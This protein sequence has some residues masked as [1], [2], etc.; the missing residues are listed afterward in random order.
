[1]LTLRQIITGKEPDMATFELPMSYDALTNI[2]RLKLLCDAD[3]RENYG[4][5]PEAQEC[6]RATNGNCRLVWD[7]TYDPPGKHFLQARL[8]IQNRPGRWPRRNY[9]PGETTLKGPLFAFVSTNVIQF[10]P[11]SNVLTE[12]G[13]FFQIKLAQPVGS[14]SLKLTSATG[15][16]IRTITGS[17]TNGIVEVHWD[18]IDDNGKRYTNDS[19]EST[20]TVTFP[21]ARKRASTNSP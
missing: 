12:K 1:M 15:E 19:L 18:L 5:E 7:T 20:W 4:N 2:G 8:S 14:Y 9:D 11:L 3:P 16:P 17:T 13:A 6:E 10:F 21:A